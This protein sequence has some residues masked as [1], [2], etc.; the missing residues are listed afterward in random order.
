MSKGKSNLNT[1]TDGND[2]EDNQQTVSSRRF[3][4]T[5]IGYP[6]VVLARAGTTTW[7]NTSWLQ[8]AVLSVGWLTALYHFLPIS[9]TASCL[10]VKH[11]YN[12]YPCVVSVP[13]LSLSASHSYQLPDC[14]VL[15]AQAASANTYTFF[16]LTPILQS[17]YCL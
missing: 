1:T 14:S 17:C 5:I 2:E 11:L 9:E 13:S 15:F 12:T 10:H 8:V 4:P 7:S 6:C 3:G 16:T